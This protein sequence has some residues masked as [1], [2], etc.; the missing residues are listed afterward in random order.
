MSWR[1]P[2]RGETKILDQAARAAA[3]GAFLTL[4]GGTTHYEIGGPPEG[5]PVV[6]VHGFSVPSYI[7]EPTFQALIGSGLRTLRYDLFGRGFS[8]RPPGPYTIDF[9]VAQLH[10]LLDALRL[11]RVALVGLSM[12]GPIAA[13]FAARFPQ[14][15][16]SLV[17]IDPV[18]F[19]P[20]PL[21]PA[22]RLAL[23]PGI[24]ELALGLLGDDRLLNGIAADFFDPEQISLFLQRYRVQMQYRG[25]KRAILSTLRGDALAG[26][27]QAYFQLA[28]QNIPILLIWGR[29]DRTIP[30]E[31][32]R[33]ILEAIPRAEFLP[34]ENCGHI[35]HY[36]RPEFVNPIL[37]RFVS[38]K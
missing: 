1:F 27:P 2:Y 24:G 15:V 12:G 36:E 19:R 38:T 5:Q 10:E 8:D 35:P 16:R 26:S 30:F 18:G 11:D 32:S 6:L 20:M 3:P 37:L 21:S 4:Q 31:N 7:W 13:T 29:N 17:L 25:F 14:R 23:L 34:V 9:F 22:L 28:G 33:P